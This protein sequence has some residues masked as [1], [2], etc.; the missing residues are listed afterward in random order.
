METP[1][2]YTVSTHKRKLTRVQREALDWLIAYKTS[3]DGN[4]P[5]TREMCDGMGIG[6]TSA[7]S[8]LLD[9]LEIAGYIKREQGTARNIVVCGGRWTYGD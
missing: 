9:K 2:T 1:G 7:A 8:Y 6:S 3:H 4:S 5:S